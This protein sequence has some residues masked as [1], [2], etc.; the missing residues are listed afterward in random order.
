M[1][2]RRLIVGRGKMAR[3]EARQAGKYIVKGYVVRR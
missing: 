2:G 3:N 1:M